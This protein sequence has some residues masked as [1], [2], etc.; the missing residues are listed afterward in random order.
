VIQSIML[1]YLIVSYVNGGFMLRRTMK[2]PLI[3]LN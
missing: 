3:L 1:T 2:R